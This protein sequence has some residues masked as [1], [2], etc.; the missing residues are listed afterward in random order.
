VYNDT[1]AER[2]SAFE[3]KHILGSN[4]WWN[5]WNNNNLLD[6]NNETSIDNLKND[7]PNNN[8]WGGLWGDDPL[9]RRWFINR[10]Y[11]GCQ[12]DPGYLGIPMRRDIGCWDYEY[13][14]KILTAR[15][16]LINFG[17]SWPNKQTINKSHCGTVLLMWMRKDIG[18][19]PYQKVTTDG[20]LKLL[21]NVSYSI[22]MKMN[23]DD[24]EII[25]RPVSLQ[26][27]NVAVL[28]GKKLY[29]KVSGQYSIS[30]WVKVDKTNGWWRNIFH[31]G[32]S[33]AH[34]A[35]A[36]W[37]SPNDSGIHYRQ[38]SQGNSNDGFDNVT[39]LEKGKWGHFVFITDSANNSITC[40]FN[41]QKLTQ[42]QL[43][44]TPVMY[45]ND[46]FYVSDPW[47]QNYDGQISIA[48]LCWHSRC[49]NNIEI[50][51]MYNNTSNYI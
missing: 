5:W 50:Q 13:C 1:E 35:P 51:S 4:D 6:S 38:A 24:V 23:V 27:A 47:Y 19:D 49:L 21:D 2:M 45:P 42:M 22:N 28:S 37:I 3:F 20:A 18:K 8:F 34:R 48:Y 44:G 17:G 41:G 40:Y 46:N 12:N 25:S 32:D 43:G 10:S 7:A 39:G 33:D 36:A 29:T 14:G 15:D 30:F 31:F 26:S 16:T 11:N 9:R